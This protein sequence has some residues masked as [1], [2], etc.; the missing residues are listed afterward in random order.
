MLQGA[1]WVVEPSLYD[2][3]ALWA[4]LAQRLQR[5]EEWQGSPTA[6][7]CPQIPVLFAAESADLLRQ[8]RRMRRRAQRMGTVQLLTGTEYVDDGRI[9]FGMRLHAL[10]PRRAPPA[11]GLTP[12]EQA[13]RREAIA[14]GRR[15]VRLEGFVVS[16]AVE[17]IFQQYIDGTLTEDECTAAVLR[18]AGGPRR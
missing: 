11:T 6:Q 3:D 7:P 10:S 1:G 13:A 8:V 5:Y 9:L 12:T 2:D 18:A 17:T 16:D 15:S 4:L 14:F